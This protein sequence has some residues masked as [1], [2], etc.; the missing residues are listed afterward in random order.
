MS[1]NKSFIMFLEENPKLFAIAKSDMC[2][3]LLKI[4]KKTAL[5]INE[6]KK[7]SY[8]SK[9]EEHD[10]ETL[11]NLLIELKLIKR[12]KFSTKNIYYTTENADEFLTIYDKTKKEFNI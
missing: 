2:I 12:E 8:F 5:P 1:Q 7:T 3:N 4:L 6:I 10:I 9:F 11:L